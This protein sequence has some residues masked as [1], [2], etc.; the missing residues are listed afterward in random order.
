MA[1]KTRTP[2]II[3]TD[4]GVDDTLAILLAITSPELEILA[5]IVSF[6]N[7]DVHAA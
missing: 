3:D 5:Y 6:G 1:E 7:T 4:P 2:I